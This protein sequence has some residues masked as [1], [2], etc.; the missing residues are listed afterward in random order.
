MRTSLLVSPLVVALCLA[1]GCSGG[2]ADEAPPAAEVGAGDALGAL[3]AHIDE[4]YARPEHDAAKV[5]VQHLL[6][7]FAGAPRQ[8]KAT[9]TRD[10]AE[11][12]TAELYARVLAGED[13]D[14]LVMEY[15]DDSHPGI[16]PMTTASRRQM[17][18]AFGDVAWRLEVGAIGVT[19][20][21][22]TAP[23]GWHIIKRLN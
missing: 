19:K 10:E 16:Y 15:T 12:L 23:A 11:A 7:G 21:D 18:P 3:R 9:R 5:E 6:V 17:F 2:A 8:T 22:G 14:D 1:A 13:F 4:L 20:Q